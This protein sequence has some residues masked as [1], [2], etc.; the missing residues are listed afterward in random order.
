MQ[1]TITIINFGT[2]TVT[3]VGLGL[4]AAYVADDP[5]RAAA[6]FQ[7]EVRAGAVYF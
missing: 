3:Y 7:G 6:A 5:R 2:L 4:G 1:P